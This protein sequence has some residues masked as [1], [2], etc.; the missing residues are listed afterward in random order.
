[1]TP[2]IIWLGDVIG[3]RVA[4]ST[5]NAEV[6]LAIPEMVERPAPLDELEALARVIESEAGDAALPEKLAVAWVA[7]NWARTRGA[8]LVSMLCAP[9]GPRAAGRP[10]STAVEPSRGAGELAFM[11]LASP[12]VDDPTR[13]ALACVDLRAS[14]MAKR[15]PRGWA[16]VGQVGR[17]V[18]VG[19][20]R[21]NLP[22]KEAP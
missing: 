5:S 15:L 1:M 20:K 6:P 12:A 3:P 22:R 14:A 16:R 10:F 8:S 18:L 21:T 9:C 2:R 17:W 11:V 4:S 19:P 7:R 13:G